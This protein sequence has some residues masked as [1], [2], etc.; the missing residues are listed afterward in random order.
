MSLEEYVSN[1]PECDPARAEYECMKRSLRLMKT[2]IFFGV[3]WNGGLLLVPIVYY[4]QQWL[5]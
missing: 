1:L 3:I 4:V 5:H 2:L